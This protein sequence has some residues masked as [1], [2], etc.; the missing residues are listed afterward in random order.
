MRSTTR[1]LSLP[2]KAA[3]FVQAWY[4]F[5]LVNVL[6][7]IYALPRLVE[8]LRT[9]PRLQSDEL[10]PAR[11][12]RIVGKALRVRGR[13]PRCLIGA[14]V[15]YRLLHERGHP[16]DLVI[17]LPEDAHDVIAHAWIEVDGV[18]VGPPPGRGHHLELAR[19]A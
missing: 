19:Y 11:L 10:A 12:G 16:G 17:G 2:E 1:P 18:D 8:R 3:I 13:S 7:R 5:V 15:L 6:L 14:L 4:W 9:A